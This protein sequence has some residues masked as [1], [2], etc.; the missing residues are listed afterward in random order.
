MA[1]VLEHLDALPGGA[2]L[3]AAVA[4]T[5]VPAYLVGGAVRD[6]L[7]GRTPRELD[8]AVEGDPEP[9]LLALGGEAER[10]PRF[11]T[12]V[13]RGDGW[14]VDVARCRVETY[15][16]PG[17]LPDVEPADIATDLLRR[18]ATINA[19]AIRLTDGREVAAPSARADLDAGVLRV[20]HDRSFL[21]DPTRLWR[22]S[23]YRARLGFA[24]EPKTDGLAAAAVDGGAL[25]RVSGTRIGNE[26]RLALREDDPAGALR[27]AVAMG[28]APW[29]DPDERRIGVVAVDAREDL[30]TLA[31]ALAPDTDAAFLHELG[32]SRAESEVLLRALAVRAGHHRP[33]GAR[34]SE[35]AEAFRG[36]PVEALALAPK[37]DRAAVRRWLD[38]LRHVRL[39]IS[40][41]DLL[42]AGVPRG[43][44]V[45]ARLE[46]ALAA[47]LNGEVPG[48]REAQLRAALAGP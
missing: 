16:Y 6:L 11:G 9:L 47:V 4:E 27:S 18:D 21:D 22:L 48:D 32:F 10:H 44:E 1:S 2:H 26:L 35:V 41:D 28:L 17:A 40:G 23:R 31:A 46:A 15:A 38:E 33:V 3:R 5:G 8:V 24:L 39:E 42:A 13:V 7:L 34:A 36:L 43:P 19:I 20:L 29:L 14:C 45:G 12:A 37:E 25:E 30:V